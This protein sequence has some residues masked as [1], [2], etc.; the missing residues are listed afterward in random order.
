MDNLNSE[1][2]DL[3]APGYDST[4]KKGFFGTLGTDL[5]EFIEGFVVIAA[6]FAFIYWQVAQPHKVSGNSMF[7][8]F[9]NGDYIL[10][11][12]V[13]Y[14]FAN[15]ERG[16]IIVFKNPRNENEDFIK[17]ILAIPGDTIKIENNSIFINGQ[18][19]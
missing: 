16:D 15:P 13:S 11:N 8:T 4:Q 6:I 7:P 12:K 2:P 10:T 19:V 14:K 18:P 3:W 17:R 1:S 9:H 5:I